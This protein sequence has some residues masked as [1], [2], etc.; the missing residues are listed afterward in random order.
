MYVDAHLAT[1][2]RARAKLQEPECTVRRY[3]APDTLVS[4]P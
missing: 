2:E 3:G 1:K 4:F